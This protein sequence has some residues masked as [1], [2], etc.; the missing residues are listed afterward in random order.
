MKFTKNYILKYVLKKADE[1]HNYRGKSFKY[2][3]DKDY[4]VHPEGFIYQISEMVKL[5][6]YRVKEIII[7]GAKPPSFTDKVE[8]LTKDARYS[9]KINAIKKQL[10]DNKSKLKD[11]V[12]E[13]T[14][15]RLGFILDYGNFKVYNNTIQGFIPYKDQKIEFELSIN[16]GQIFYKVCYNDKTYGDIIKEQTIH[17]VDVKN[18]ATKI[19]ER[20]VRAVEFDPVNDKYNYVDSQKL[21]S[22]YDKN[23]RQMKKIK[24]ESNRD[25]YCGK[26]PSPYYHRNVT[27]MTTI[28]RLL[29]NEYVISKHVSK[30]SFKKD[31]PENVDESKVTYAIS[32]NVNNGNQLNEVFHP[33]EIDV[34]L[35]RKAIYGDIEAVE[36]A[37]QIYE[38]HKQMQA[39]SI[40]RSRSRS[41]R[42]LSIPIPT[43]EYGAF[44][45]K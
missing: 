33:L 26:D 1:Y 4:Y 17:F 25:L 28:Y 8:R 21:I 37:I 32:Y 18:Y 2:L 36:K 16:E 31:V 19:I 30:H 9:S 5:P 40:V 20:E 24:I 22:Y 3:V 13:E 14:I 35:A 44:N 11:G 7:G 27:N 12:L 34:D 42:E 39:E 45:V 6:E 41:G 15:F 23:G 10:C 38:N 43:L 29:I